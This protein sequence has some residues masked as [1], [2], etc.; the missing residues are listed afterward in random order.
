MLGVVLVPMPTLFMDV[1]IAAN[2][3]L[4]ALILL[5]TIFV[6]SPLDFSVFRRCC[7]G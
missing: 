7:L 6:E 1:L 3:T 4:A 5:T 2:L